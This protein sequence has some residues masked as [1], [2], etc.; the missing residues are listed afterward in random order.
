MK[1][2]KTGANLMNFDETYNRL[3][4]PVLG[5]IRSRLNRADAAEEVCAGVWQKA[6]ERREQFDPERGS[7][8]QW[9]FGI[10][11]NEVNKYF[12][13]WQFKRFFSPGERE[14]Q[15]PSADKTP[16]ETLEQNEKNKILLAAMQTLNARERD[17]VALKFFAGLNNRQTARLCGLSESNVGTIVSRA[18]HKLRAYMEDL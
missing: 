15:Y 11:R 3:F 10:A 17:L 6:W 1:A 2:L 12:G 13:F 16:P 18:V 8:D 4:K 14:E 9:I 7:P 5:Y